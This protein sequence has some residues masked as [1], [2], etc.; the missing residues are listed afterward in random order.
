[1]LREVKEFVQRLKNL[2]VQFQAEEELAGA[3]GGSA[4]SLMNLDLFFRSKKELQS[5]RVRKV[6]SQLSVR[7]LKTLGK[8]L[9][10]LLKQADSCCTK[11]LKIACLRGMVLV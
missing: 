2:V 11:I 8:S 10:V 1:M 3:M 9:N 7:D 6:V 4:Q 5:I